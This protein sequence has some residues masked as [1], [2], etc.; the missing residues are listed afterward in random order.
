MCDCV[1]TVVG[2]YVPDD[3]FELRSTFAELYFDYV[4]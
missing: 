3:L 1:S 4:T 2:C